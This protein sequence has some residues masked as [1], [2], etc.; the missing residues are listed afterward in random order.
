MSV[1]LA[2][3]TYQAFQC[4]CGA[5]RSTCCRGWG[6]TVSMPEYFKLVGLPC[7][8]HLRRRLDGAFHLVEHPTPERYAM[9]APNWEGDCPLRAR[10]G[11]C[12]LHKE[13]GEKALPSICRL[14]PRRIIGGACALSGSCEG[15]IEALLTREE[16]IRFVEIEEKSAAEPAHTPR[17]E[18]MAQFDRPL[19]LLSIG[20]LQDRRHH[21]A[22]RMMLLGRVMADIYRYVRAQDWAGMGTAIAACAA[23]PAEA[24]KRVPYRQDVVE[25]AFKVAEVFSK[26]SESLA[27]DWAAGMQNLARADYPEMRRVFEQ[28]HPNWER[29]FEHITVNHAFFSRFPYTD[30]HADLMAEYAALC[31]AHCVVMYLS[32]IYTYDKEGLEPLA[33]VI[34]AAFRMIE[35]SDFARRAH[36]VF[37]RLGLGTQEK[38]DE[39]LCAL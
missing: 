29:H 9:I 35:H 23:E 6:I 27:G 4:K 36:I 3:D 37:A 10:D 14:Y 22:E 19:R 30:I 24:P 16:P 20:I 34:A 32:T 33:D 21:I 25:A 28:K 1:F 8:K 39:L 2:P 17:N 38:L 11:L 15:V 31:A 12:L 5:C 18:G 26:N 7:G 13:Q